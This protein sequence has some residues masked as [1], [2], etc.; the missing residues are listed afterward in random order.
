MVPASLLASM[1][2]MLSSMGSVSRPRP[3]TVVRVVDAVE[4]R[5][6]AVIK[7]PVP[8]Q[9]WANRVDDPPQPDPILFGGPHFGGGET[10][11]GRA[12]V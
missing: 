1:T 7:V 6:I 5:L 4:D 10:E 11:I 2:T 3:S 8:Q 12:H 9:L